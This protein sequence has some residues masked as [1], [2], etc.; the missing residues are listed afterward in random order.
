[1]KNNCS[2]QV[3][4]IPKISL[5]KPPFG[6]TSAEVAIIFLDSFW[7]ILGS[8][9]SATQLFVVALD[10]WLPKIIQDVHGFEKKNSHN[11]SPWN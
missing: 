8:S 7:L 4:I 9:D 5:S 6:V 3:T 11:Y 1:M 10:S 2:G